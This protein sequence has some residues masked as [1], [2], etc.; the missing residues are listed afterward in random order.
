VLLVER[1]LARL[2]HAR[3]DEELVHVGYGAVLYIVE[4][5]NASRGNYGPGS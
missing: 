5:R 2:R 1:V 4:W 3:D